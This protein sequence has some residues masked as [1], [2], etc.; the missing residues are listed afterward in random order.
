[1]AMA[2]TVDENFWDPTPKSPPC[3]FP[4]C[5]AG[6]NSC[7]TFPDYGYGFPPPFGPHPFSPANAVLGQFGQGTAGRSG[8]AGLAKINTGD[9]FDK[10]SKKALQKKYQFGFGGP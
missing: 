5:C 10:K 4:T 6:I 1:M 9:W 2:F 7:P 3:D 8:A